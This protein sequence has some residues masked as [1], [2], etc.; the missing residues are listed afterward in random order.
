MV[1]LLYYIVQMTI[2][3]SIKGDIPEKIHS[4]FNLIY[5]W[6]CVLLFH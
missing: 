3:K 1:R 4:T 5:D 2:L 6:W